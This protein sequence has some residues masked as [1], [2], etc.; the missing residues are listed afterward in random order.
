MAITKGI[1][2]MMNGDITVQSEKGVGTEFTVTV[3]LRNSE[4][5]DEE[6][7][8]PAA[9]GSDR[10]Q[11]RLAGRR[12]L[13][14]EDSEE[15]HRHMGFETVGEFHRCIYKFGRWYNMIWM[16]D[17]LKMSQLWRICGC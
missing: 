15:F 11:V 3:T 1:V 4:C 12:I 2:E 5:R 14:A 7:R 8:E 17:S 6:H 9:R 10:K 13:L 16:E